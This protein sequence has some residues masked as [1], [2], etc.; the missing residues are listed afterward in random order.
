MSFI[1]K[2]NFVFS[3]ISNGIQTCKIQSA[4][5]ADIYNLYWTPREDEMK[6]EL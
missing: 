2:N 5:V 3:D 6:S 4:S 1:E